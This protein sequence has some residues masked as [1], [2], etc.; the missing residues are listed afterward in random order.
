MNYRD[1]KKSMDRGP[2]EFKSRVVEKEG[3][4]MLVAERNVVTTHPMNSIKNVAKLMKEH[5]F[6][7]IPVTDAGTKRLEGLAVAI[8]I[9]D[10]LGGGRKYNI[11]LKDYNGN[12]LSAINCPISKIMANAMYVEKKDKIDD[13]IEI[14]MNK[15]T[16]AIP[17][18]DNI[19]NR[20][21]IAI[22]TE[23]DILPTGDEFGISVR[24]SMRKKCITSSLGMRISD[25]SK[26]MVR[27]R[28]RRLPVILEDRLVGIVTVF[29]V[30]KFIGYGEF[31][32]VRGSSVEE[33]LDERVER[34]MEKD[35][36]TVSPDQDIAEVSTLIK[37]TGYG[38]FPVIEDAML[39]GI[40]TSSDV[41]RSIYS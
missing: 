24:E 30:L 12:F 10:F 1:I 5:D 9:L 31:K 41:I 16:S 39:I 40:I 15:R 2:R 28:L 26:I 19:E 23:R 27:N 8:D 11:I 20:K 6:R 7:R 4:V 13:V 37:K 36:V 17:I 29:D 32:G 21:V 33:I 25:V 35:V 34:I 38:G 3:N 22:V 18:V 14:M